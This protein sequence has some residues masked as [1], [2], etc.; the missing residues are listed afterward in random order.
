MHTALQR[1]AYAAPMAKP[2]DLPARLTERHGRMTI[3]L[4]LNK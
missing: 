1:E 3:G 2:E 4:T